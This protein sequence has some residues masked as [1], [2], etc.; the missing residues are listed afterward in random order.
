[1]AVR[2]THA[3]AAPAITMTA[4]PSS[5]RSWG[6][7]PEGSEAAASTAAGPRVTMIMTQQAAV[8]EAVAV[9]PGREGAASG[10]RAPSTAD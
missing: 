6:E 7:L 5:L 4:T 8:V 10:R 1:M 3:S 9:E 2:P